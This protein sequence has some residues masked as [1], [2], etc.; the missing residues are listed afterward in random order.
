MADTTT[1]EETAAEVASLENPE[2][3]DTSAADE[4]SA[5]A[6]QAA[7]EGSEPTAA[8]AEDAAEDEVIVTIGDEAPPAAEEDDPA[9]APGWLKDLRKANREKDRA[10]REKDAEIARLKAATAPP[11]A[12]PVGEKPTLASCDF[13]EAKF[14]TA[15]EAW[16]ERKRKA[17]D[18]ARE[19]QEQAKK[20]QDAWN[21]K[22]SAYAQSKQ[23]LKIKGFED[24][25]EAVL[26][27]LSQVQQGI[28]VQ[29]A[30]NPA[31]V[32]AAIGMNPKKLAE[33]AAIKDPVQFAVAV[34]EL[35]AQLK[36]TNRKPATA[37]EKTAPRSSMSGASAV[38][39]QLA[40]LQETAARTGDRTPVIRYLQGREKQAA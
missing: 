40:K 22:L 4:T 2:R 25:E 3:S 1:T 33:L 8:A 16:H 15:L 9:K 26:H 5:G 19:Q 23:A 14:E 30:K 12:E 36:V 11:A 37:P 39:N 35:G 17:D 6:E 34:G 29:G 13:D 28:I 21:A 24:A 38:D 18:A 7:A 31:L 10:L 20:A 27:G 32:V